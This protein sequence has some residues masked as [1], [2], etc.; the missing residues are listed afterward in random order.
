MFKTTRRT[1]VYQRGASSIEEA[2]LLG[3]LVVASAAVDI[4][5]S[6]MRKRYVGDW[7]K[8]KKCTLGCI[9]IKLHL[10]WKAASHHLDWC[11]IDEVWFLTAD[12]LDLEVGRNS[13]QWHVCWRNHDVKN[14]RLEKDICELFDRPVG[15]HV[16]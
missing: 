6:L 11:D 2:H 12:V 9:K 13:A 8:H 5:S 16:T 15:M 14:W 7:L 1:F 4:G 3:E 10:C